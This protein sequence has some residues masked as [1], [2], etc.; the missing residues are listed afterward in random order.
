MVMQKIIFFFLICIL[1][2][3][4]CSENKVAMHDNPKADLGHLLFFERNISFNHTKSCASCHSP[5]MAFTDGYRRSIAANGENAIHN[6]PSILNLSFNSFYDW[7]NNSITNLAKQIKR[8][9]YNQHPKELGFNEDTIALFYFFEQ[10]KIYHDL[11][12]KAFPKDTKP[13]NCL[14]V[15]SCLVEYV[16]NLKASSAKYDRYVGGEKSIFSNSEKRGMDLFFSSQL[17]CGKCHVPPLFTQN[18]L[19]KNADTVYANI[20][21]YNIENKNRYPIAD[22]GLSRI[23]KQE[24]DDGKF[25][26]PSLRNVLLTAP[27]MHDGSVASI[28]EVID[29]YAAGGRIIEE[30]VLK[31]DGRFNENKHPF[32]KGFSISAEE[33]NDLI[34][35]L[36]TLTDTSYLGNPYFL[37]PFRI[38]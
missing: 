15:E 19:S 18:N 35:F 33:K 25:K 23:T 17:Q 29:L 5:E 16:K 9:L 34:Q 10:N 3:W 21:L 20:G 26:I 24:K 30:G 28:Q 13:I 14:N 2:F 11:F 27:Y 32:I 38:K 1:S 8:P 31:G 4:G 12:Q 7:D 6:A 36:S 22:P 37:N